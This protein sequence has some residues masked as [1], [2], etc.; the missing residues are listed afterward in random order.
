MASRKYAKS[1][2]IDL[3]YITIGSLQKEDVGETVVIHDSAN[4]IQRWN[5]VSIYEDMF[6]NFMT[7]EIVLVDQD[8]M[9]LNRFRTEEV[10][11]I[12]FCTPDL[13]GRT[14]QPRDHYFYLYKI[15]PV[16]ILN[17]PNGA[18]YSIRGISFEFFYNT[19]RTFS[20]SFKPDRTENIAKEIY[21][22]FLEAKSERTV[23]KKFTVG[24]PTRHEMKFSFPYV[25]P[26]DAINHLASVSIDST[27]PD[28]C[29][30]VFYED[31]DGF[32]FKS[33]TEL[34]ERPRKVHKYI[35]SKT[36]SVPFANFGAYFDNTITITPTRGADKIIDTLDGVYGEF[37]ADYDL[38]YKSYKPYMFVERG[39]GGN[40]HGKRY[41]EYFPKTKH[42]N[43]KPVLSFENELFRDPLGRNR[44]CFSNKALYSEKKKLD[45]GEEAWQLYQT[46][47][48]E[49]SFQR[50]S[51]MQ[52]INSMSVELVVPGNSDITV[53]DIVDLDTVIY[54]SSDPDLYL[55]GKYLVTAVHHAINLDGYKSIITISRDSIKSNDFTD[56]SEAGE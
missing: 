9:F 56:D 43:Q 42:L 37:F 54:R 32:N 46:H 55:S 47:E 44:I 49:Y 36:S 52:Q 25:N 10:I 45:N 31:K 33:I 1:L 14:F 15:D 13:D 12:R 2:D 48:E 21:K 11:L 7:C 27:N 50:R 18:V 22:E 24:R 5:A 34:I 3:Q 53:G 16:M 51:L 26:V 39:R 20:K 40:V 4:N 23:K 8:G 17:K 35:T 19:L 29:N 6:K 28:I 30:Y 38:M 41:L